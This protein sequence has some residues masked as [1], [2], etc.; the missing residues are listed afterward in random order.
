MT[1][2]LPETLWLHEHGF[3]DLLLGYPATDRAALARLAE[4]DG[5]PPRPC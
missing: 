1:F 4:L 3:D 5:R 2:T